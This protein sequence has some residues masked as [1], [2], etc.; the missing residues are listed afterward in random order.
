M[1]RSLQSQ[2]L[3][4]G[5]TSFQYLTFV[6]TGMLPKHSHQAVHSRAVPITE[7]EAIYLW[8]YMG[9]RSGRGLSAHK[10]TIVWMGTLTVMLQLLFQCW[11]PLLDQMNIL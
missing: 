8:N 6:A 9:C 3:V 10:H 2:F 7:T 4:A 5:D 1:Y 11:Q